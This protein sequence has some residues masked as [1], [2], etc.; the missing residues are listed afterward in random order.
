MFDPLNPKLVYII[1][2]N[3]FPTANK[4]QHSLLRKKITVWSENHMKHTNTLRKHN[5]ELLNV[6]AGGTQSY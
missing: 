6:K 1:F 3:L 2:K 4:T 5:S